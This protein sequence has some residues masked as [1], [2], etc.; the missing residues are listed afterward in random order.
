VT[1]MRKRS[2]AATNW[3]PP[4]QDPLLRCVRHLYTKGLAPGQGLR[5]CSGQPVST[6]SPPHPRAHGTSCSR[7][8]VPPSIQFRAWDS[9]TCS[10][11]ATQARQPARVEA[12]TVWAEGLPKHE[13]PSCCSD[14]FRLVCGLET[15]RRHLWGHPLFLEGR[16]DSGPP[17]GGGV[18]PRFF[19]PG[20]T[21]G[22]R[23]LLLRRRGIR[24]ALPP[25]GQKR[26][27][28][29]ATRR[30]RLPRP[31]E[32]TEQP[33][34]SLGPCSSM[35]PTGVEVADGAACG[36]QRQIGGRN[37]TGHRR[38]RLPG[39]QPPSNVGSQFSGWK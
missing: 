12:E 2:A 23:S 27:H 19:L 17:A 28:L 36:R 37:L 5:R 24:T 8:R 29:S 18:P 7:P 33:F 13:L 16:W 6:S 9:R 20:G 10:R 21:Q 35:G 34:A 1:P 11:L 39:R 22:P 31:G 15:R 4:S 26:A 32:R 14:P 38:R 30:L 3:R 25:P